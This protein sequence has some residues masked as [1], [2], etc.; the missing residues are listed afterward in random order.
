MEGGGGAGKTDRHT[1]K[2]ERTR[3][4]S[5]L[6]A[7]V[8]DVLMEQRGAYLDRDSSAERA[9]DERNNIPAELTRR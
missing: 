5:G 2:Q 8:V 1:Q 3:S 7:D 4:D 6:L 9:G